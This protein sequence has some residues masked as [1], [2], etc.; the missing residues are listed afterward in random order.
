[1]MGVYLFGMT[2]LGALGGFALKQV[3]SKESLLGKLTVFMCGCLL[4]GLGAILNVMALRTFPYTI[5]FPL[6][7][8][9]YIWT[10]ILS[11]FYLKEKIN[12]YKWIGLS[13]IIAG[14]FVIAL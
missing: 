14:A 5:V 13:L 9:T 6:T 4:Y 3:S 11:Y 10:F 2:L 1:M 12:L 7:S 8:L